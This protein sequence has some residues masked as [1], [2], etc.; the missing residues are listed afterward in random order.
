MAKRMP[1]SRA[2]SRKQSALGFPAELRK[3]MARQYQPMLLTLIEKPFDDP[4]WL[5]EPKYDGLRVLARMDGRE[6]KLISRNGKLQN[7]QFPD[8][9]QGLLEAVKESAVVD[10]EMVCLDERGRSS[11]RKLQQRLHLLDKDEIRRRAQTYPAYFYV[12]D[13]LYWDGYELTSLPLER[14]KQVLSNAVRWSDR[15]RMTPDTPARGIAMFREA[16]RNHEEG[17]VGKHLGSTYV[18]IRSKEW[19]KIKCI[20][21]QEFVIGGWTDPQRSRVGLGA[22]LVGY[23]TDDGK[24]FVYAGKVGTG[25]ARETLVD[26]AQRLGEISQQRS[27]FDG[28]DPPQGSDVH[29]VKPR[30]VAEIAFGEWTQ[31]GLLRQ[32]RFEGLRTDKNAEDVVRERPKPVDAG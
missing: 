15:I 9:E 24:H 23:F 22:I 3:P 11:F 27:A 25:F 28:G 2:G 21:G 18:G 26:L 1:R 29:W 6:V 20:S 4:Q 10:G 12:F 30:L 16:S 19:V 14:R 5:F 8:I 31:N 17:I 7:L 13:I 32:P